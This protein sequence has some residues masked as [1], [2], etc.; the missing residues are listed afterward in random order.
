MFQNKMF[1]N[2]NKITSL[3]INKD[4][5]YVRNICPSRNKLESNLLKLYSNYGKCCIFPSGMNAIY[6]IFSVMHKNTNVFLNDNLY[7]EVPLLLDAMP[8]LN[9]KTIKS[10]IDLKLIN[11]D[12]SSIFY[13]ESCTNPKG[14]VF[15]FDQIPYL[16]KQ[17]RNCTV[18]CDNTW[19]SPILLNPFK[20]QVDIVVESTTK[21]LS[22]GMRIGGMC[23]GNDNIFMDKL[24]KH[25]EMTGIYYSPGDCDVVD[26]ELQFLENRMKNLSRI[27]KD[28]VK[29][30]EV[31]PKIDKVYYPDEKVCQK[32]LNS[33]SPACVN[34]HIKTNLTILQIHKMIEFT[35]I[36]IESSYG[37]E[38][39]RILDYMV[40]DDEGIFIRLSIGYKSNKNEIINNLEKL[41]SYC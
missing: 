18:I 37:G 7:F 12:Q 27:T 34:F 19:L 10:E 3:V 38:Y 22:G 9:V 33:L 13:F 21:Y 20:Y 36:R 26:Y 24:R 4:K 16:K 15:D 39:N 30:L 35:N 5:S 1:R 25:S 11:S 28:V 23:I 40:K 6:N 17:N 29:F 32:Y 14:Q 2:L 41:F 31:H 8:H